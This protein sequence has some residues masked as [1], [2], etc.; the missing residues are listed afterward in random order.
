MKTRSEAVIS[1]RCTKAERRAF[2]RAARLCDKT[3]SGFMNWAARL[4][5]D[6]SP[7][8]NGRD[9]APSVAAERSRSE[10][11]NEGAEPVTLAPPSSFRKE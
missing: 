1:V 9:G 2:K 6:T 4:A 8:L 11:R 10:E 5:M 3:L 7:S